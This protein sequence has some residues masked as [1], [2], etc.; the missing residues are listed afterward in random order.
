[1]NSS[2]NEM[3]RLPRQTSHFVRDVE[4]GRAGFE[5]LGAGG[6]LSGE[7]EGNIM[8]DGY[9]SRKRVDEWCQSTWRRILQSVT[10]SSA[11]DFS[12]HDYGNFGVRRKMK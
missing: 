12:I 2:Q 3:L 8:D 5:A 6:G 9:D 4:A 7:G 10:Q 11:T 1:M